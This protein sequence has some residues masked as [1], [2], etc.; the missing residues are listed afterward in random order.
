MWI[1]FSVLWWNY[2]A[3]VL[4]CSFLLTDFTKIWVLFLLSGRLCWILRLPVPVLFSRSDFCSC[5]CLCVHLRD[6]IPACFSQACV[7]FCARIFVAT[8][9]VTKFGGQWKIDSHRF[10]RILKNLE[11]FI[12][13]WENSVKMQLTCERIR[14]FLEIWNSIKLT[15]L[16]AE[17]A[18][19]L[20]EFFENSATV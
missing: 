20:A 2:F 4:C 8:A 5:F 7:H 15:K 13:N 3:L 17:F 18:D 9:S 16:L 14:K 19:N 10:R 1:L 12:E 11:K 6:P